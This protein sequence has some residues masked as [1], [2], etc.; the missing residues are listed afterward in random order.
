MVGEVEL[1]ARDCAVDISE[2]HALAATCGYDHR[3]LVSE[4]VSGD[5]WG[6]V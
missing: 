5:D 1:V 4:C 6:D 2:P 3:S